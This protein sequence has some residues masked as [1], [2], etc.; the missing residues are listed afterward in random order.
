[1]N[2]KFCVR[3]V[4]HELESWYIGDMNAIHAIFPR[5]NIAQYINKNKFRKP[6][7]C[8]NPKLELRKILGDYPQIAT[9]REIGKYMTIKDNTSSSFQH[10]VSGVKRFV[11]E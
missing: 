2:I 9:A 7:M 11:Q 8:V 5:F 4:C 1:D 3:I 10:F 6:D